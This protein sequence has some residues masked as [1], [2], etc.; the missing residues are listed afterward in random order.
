MGKTY[1]DQPEVPKY[2]KNKKA[3]KWNKEKSIKLKFKDLEDDN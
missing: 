2:T 1:K 3:R